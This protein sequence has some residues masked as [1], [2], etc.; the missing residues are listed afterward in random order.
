MTILEPSQLVALLVFLAVVAGIIVRVIDETVAALAGV[1]I[2]VIATQYT[3]A[4][5]FHAVDWNVVAILLGMW[6]ITGYM[7]EAGFAELVVALVAKRVSNYRLFLTA[8]ILLAG[9]VSILV[10]NVLVILLFG[11]I[12]LEAARRTGGNP[13]LAILMVG[14]AANFMGTA[15]LMGDLPPQLL[16]SVAG[17]EFVDFLWSHGLPGSF[18]LLSATFIIVVLAMYRLFISKEPKAVVRVD[19]A[20][21]GRK[22]D[23]QV[24][25]ISLAGFTATVAGMALRPL[26]GLPLGFI[27]LAGAAATSLVAEA[28]ARAARRGVV[29][30]KALGHVEWRALLFYASLFALVGGLEA[31]HLLELAAQ[32]FLGFLKSDPYTAYTVF[33]WVVAAL[34]SIVEHDALL[35]T[36]L[37]LVRDAASMVGVN[38]WPLYWAMAWSATLASNLTVAAAPAL[39]VAIS[40]AEKAGYRVAPRTFFRYSL[41]FVIISLV[42]HY[43]ITLPLWAPLLGA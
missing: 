8:M 33:Y 30:E 4:E 2:L 35:L 32:E 18:P 39:Y 38:A 16:H 10:D 24:L 19:P 41:P 15:L 1:V 27:T 21:L 14:F 23:K 17:A 31:N 9:F 42:V 5:A 20:L 28:Y 34:A 37:Y 26:L 6:I 36:F 13:V 12:V 11:T 43:V 22:V 29:F 40:I 3:P 7:I 25:V